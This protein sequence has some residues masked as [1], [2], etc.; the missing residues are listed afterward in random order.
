[1]YR[2]VIPYRQLCASNLILSH[3]SVP[4]FTGTPPRPA[5]E[6]PHDESTPTFYARFALPRNR[7]NYHCSCLTTPVHYGYVYMARRTVCYS[8]TSSLAVSWILIQHDTLLILVMLKFICDS[9]WNTEHELSS[10]PTITE[11]PVSSFLACVRDEKL[12]GTTLEYTFYC[13]NVIVYMS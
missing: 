7:D 3:D 10:S 13:L 8:P 6:S 9:R 5:H 11:T 1:M 2:R 4:L 12:N